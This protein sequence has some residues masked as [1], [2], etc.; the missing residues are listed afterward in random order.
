M[1]A[2]ITRALGSRQF[3]S[4]VAESL[5]ATRRVARVAA[6]AAWQALV[7]TSRAAMLVETGARPRGRL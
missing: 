7:A 4:A 6:R 5:R 2:I 3:E 1:E